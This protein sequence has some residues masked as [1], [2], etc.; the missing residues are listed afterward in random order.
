[1]KKVKPRTE[2][3]SG[4]WVNLI[5]LGCSKN[6]VDSEVML[7][8]LLEDGFNITSKES[9]SDIVIINTC[10]FINPA[11]QESFKTINNVL[12]NKHKEQKI[13]VSGCLVQRLKHKIIDRFPDVDA[14]L[15]VG[16]F[17]KIS[18]ICKKLLKGKKINKLLVSKP[19]FIYNEDTPRLLCTPLHTAYVKI[20]EGC[21]NRCFYCVIPSI[22]GNLRSRPIESIVKEVKNLEKLGVKEINLISQDTTN[23]GIDL[24]GKPKLV[25]LLKR[26]TEVKGIKWIR[27]FYLYPSDVSDDLINLIA[28][29]NK[30]C[31]YIDIP[32]Q[33]I[34]NQIL[35]LM[36]R[37]YTFK[38]IDTLI[39][40]MKKKI[41]E[42]VFRTTFI[43]GYPNETEEKFQSLV[44]FVKKVKF[45]KLGVFMFSKEKGTIA[46]FLEGQVSNK[47]KNKRKNIIMKL[48]Q[49]ISLELNKLKIGSKIS[50]IVD[51]MN[52]N[53]LIGR[54]EG[55]ALDVDGKVYIQCNNHKKINPGDFINV[56]VK[57]AYPYDLKG[58]IL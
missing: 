57:E 38:E 11:T 28:K 18:H 8:K 50:M 53:V 48:Q 42:A 16:E 56:K 47:V 1:M 55:D 35:R 29:S 46:E 41:P 31:K 21:N 2:S 51:R 3:H 24:Y 49:K 15:G 37:R 9:E 30:I 13:V 26:L 32:L 58:E 54:T 40:K 33:H 19:E 12:K 52:K 36:G 14:F 17:Y 6:L 45:S 10:C 44:K 7:G 39:K 43:V 22:R 20:S 25:K 23:Y 4:V 5:S 34:D 27:L